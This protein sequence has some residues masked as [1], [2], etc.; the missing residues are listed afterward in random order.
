MNCF[1]RIS[2]FIFTT[3]II[4]S[5]A[6]QK[7]PGGGEED[8]EAPKIIFHFPESEI[9]NFKGN[10]VVIEFNE[11][12]DKRSFID[13][14]FF[15]PLITDYEINWSG[16]QAEIIFPESI[17]K[18]LPNKTILVNLRSDLKD[19][20]GNSLNE[21]FSFAFSTGPKIDKGMV[22]GKVFN[23]SEKVISVMASKIDTSGILFNPTVNISDYQTQTSEDGGF[24]FTNLSPGK[25]RIFGVKDEDRNL[26]YTQDREDY[27]VLWHDIIINDSDIINNANIFLH[28]LDQRYESDPLDVTSYFSDSLNLIYCSIN[29]GNNYVLPEQSIYFYLKNH[30]LSRDKFVSTFKLK[31]DFEKPVKVVFNWKND[32]IV[33]VFPAQK[34]SLIR[35]YDIKFEIKFNPDSVYI[36]NLKFKTVSENSFGNVDGMFNTH[37]EE[38][39]TYSKCIKLYHK[40]KIPILIYSGVFSNSVFLFEKIF[41]GNYSLFSFIDSDNSETYN[42]GKLFP[43]EYSEPFYFYPQEIRV[44]GGWTTENIIINFSK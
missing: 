2:L 39:E 12:V 42:F 36:Y 1:L 31:E 6:N 22:K 40:E 26:L 32:S 17:N 24:I 27:G 30:V 35:D 13:A 8:R 5:C 29:N 14:L 41:E 16:K 25:Y 23:T 28:K 20:Y 18:M 33:E 44:K 15:S 9:T 34:F 43:F 10:R 11:Y 7:P 4:F 38:F 37:K 21:P 3:V 19:L